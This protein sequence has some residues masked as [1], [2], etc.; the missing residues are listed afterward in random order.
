[1]F[2]LSRKTERVKSIVLLGCYFFLFLSV[3]WWYS[4]LTNYFASIH[5][6]WC[7]ASV[8]SHSLSVLSRRFWLENLFCVAYPFTCDW[9]CLVP[10]PVC[11]R[12]CS[13]N[14]YWTCFETRR[15]LARGDHQDVYDFPKI[16]CCELYSCNVFCHYDCLCFWVHSWYSHA[17]D[18]F[19]DLASKSSAAS[20][21]R[22]RSML[23]KGV[24]GMKYSLKLGNW[25]WYQKNIP[26]S[27]FSDLS[28]YKQTKF[29]LTLIYIC[30]QFYGITTCQISV[31]WFLTL[32][33]QLGE[34]WGNGAQLVTVLL[35][36]FAPAKMLVCYYKHYVC[37]EIWQYVNCVY[38]VDAEVK[39]DSFLLLYSICE[40][41][42]FYPQFSDHAKVVW[43]NF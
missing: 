12:I 10:G 41:K 23:L 40:W 16:N 11:N 36:F 21:F 1:M 38:A 7:L 18:C 3:H 31:K 8:V 39:I 6:D 13:A 19:C 27:F 2:S 4:I 28:K 26:K 20:V 15:G 22:L 43:N 9:L 5:R 30:T 32:T 29:V 33:F 35:V 14:H 42:I 37:W 24:L 25:Y 34:I 17:L